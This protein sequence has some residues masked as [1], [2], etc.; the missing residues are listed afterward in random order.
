M[1]S[2]PILDIVRQLVSWKS[3]EFLLSIISGI[4]GKYNQRDKFEV[5]PESVPYLA[6]LV[7]YSEEVRSRCHI[8]H[9]APTPEI[10]AFPQ[11]GSDIFYFH[12]H[13]FFKWV[14]RFA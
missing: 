2:T 8:K 13:F 1:N 6:T 4:V 10:D 12:L 9:P 7:A 3:A 5:T 14:F 11:V